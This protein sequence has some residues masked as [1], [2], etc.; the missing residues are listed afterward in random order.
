MYLLHKKLSFNGRSIGQA[1]NAACEFVRTIKNKNFV[2][3]HIN[4][5]IIIMI[6]N[7]IYMWWNVSYHVMRSK[8]NFQPKI[9]IDLHEINLWTDNI[10]S[11]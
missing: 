8:I 9:Y 5:T 3:N 7:I 2:G 10:F 1:K 11:I 4:L 6:T